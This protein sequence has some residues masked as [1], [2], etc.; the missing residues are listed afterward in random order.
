MKRLATIFLL[1]CCAAQPAA[2]QTP[3]LP[4]ANIG[5]DEKLGQ[6][7]ALD[8]TL[9]DEQ[10]ERVVLRTLV[11]KPTVLTLNY[12]RCAGICTPLLNGVADVIGKT[13]QT[14]GKDFQVLTV[15]FDPRDNPEI[16]GLKRNNYVK[17]LGAGFPPSAWRFLTGD[18]ASTKRLA[19]SVGFKFAKAGNDYVHPGAIMILSPAGKVSRY[20]YGV[21]F[22]PFDLKM[23]LTEAAEGRTGPTINS[24]L[25]LC[26]SYDPAGRTY[27]FNITRVVGAF[28]LLLAAVFA[29]VT[30][31]RRRRPKPSEQPS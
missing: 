29:S 26:Y 10:G 9:L 31:I 1:L 15:S 11:D 27:F 16:A 28:T 7:V 13:G 25:M 12:F 14:P 22:L 30:L 8:T 3:A 5:I 20:M 17:Q 21:R 19:D 23:A 6:T 24:L 4:D 2:A 18:P